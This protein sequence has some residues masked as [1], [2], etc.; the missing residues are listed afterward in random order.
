[1]NLLFT[2][3][4]NAKYFEPTNSCTFSSSARNLVMRQL[5]S[6]PI[7]VYHSVTTPSSA[8]NTTSAKHLIRVRLTKT[9]NMEK[10][11]RKIYL[12]IEFVSHQE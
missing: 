1:M 10:N 6:I 5:V 9:V 11:A 8:L 12:E 3:F 4:C 7:Y 2:K